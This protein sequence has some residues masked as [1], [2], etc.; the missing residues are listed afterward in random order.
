MTAG[1]S[2][3]LP[4][5]SFPVLGSPAGWGPSDGSW[6]TKVPAFHVLTYFT[7]PSSSD[8]VNSL[9]RPAGM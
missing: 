2:G 4:S 9:L 5:A 6:V 3:Q 1:H 7:D 8:D